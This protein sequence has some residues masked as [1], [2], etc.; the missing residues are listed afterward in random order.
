MAPGLLEASAMGNGSISVVVPSLNEAQNLET[1][2][3]EILAEI[4]RHFDD[5][6]ILIVN[7]G[8][9]DQTGEIAEALAR[10]HPAVRVFHN[11]GNQGYGKSYFRGVSEASKDYVVLVPG[12]GENDL[13]GMSPLWPLIGTAD[14]IVPFTLNPE[15]RSRFRRV[16]SRLGTLTM[17]TLFGMRLRYYN[18]T[19]VCRTEALRRIRVETWGYLF[20]AESLI[21][22]VAGGASYREVGIRV[23]P[24]AFGRSKLFT[25][26]NL[27]EVARTL[28]R[29][30]WQ[31]RVLRRF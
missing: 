4:P 31:R 17:N 29:L 14:L 19:V 22:L 7:D 12:D 21:R 26:R 15:I 30:A 13:A 8:S 6:E 24:R 10:Q 3:A 23:R 28:A 5:F 27:G 9:T 2:V 20:Q 1:T 16:F 18:G 11:P 25:A